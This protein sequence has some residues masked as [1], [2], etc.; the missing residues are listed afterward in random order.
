MR[1]IIGERAI[2][3]IQ[4]K[5]DLGDVIR[6]RVLKT[7]GLGESRV[8]QMIGDLFRNSVN[9]SIGV[10]AHPGQV[11][12]RITARAKSISEAEKM[13]DEMEKEINAI[14]GDSIYGIGEITLD[15]VLSKLLVEKNKTL[16]IVETNSGGSVIQRLGAWPQ[17]VSF[18]KRGVVGF[19]R[20]EVGQIL[21]FP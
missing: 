11:D 21:D 14:L 18:L 1:Y 6:T 2:P 12:V 20:E 15:E 13:T 8:D 5:F 4:E 10:L 19:N 16:S 7:C 17:R 9:P 3:I